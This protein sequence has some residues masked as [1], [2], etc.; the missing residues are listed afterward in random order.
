M[1]AVLVWRIAVVVLAFDAM[2][3][4]SGTTITFTKSPDTIQPSLTQQMTLRCSLSD[5]ASTHAPTTAAPSGG[6]LVGRRDAPGDDIKFVTSVV[7]ARDGLD[8]ASVSEHVAAR[9][10]ADAG[11][12]SVEGKITNTVGE[13][14]FLELTWEDP[15]MTQ[16]GNYTC[17]VAGVDDVGHNV[18]YTTYSFVAQA[19]LSIMDLIPYIHAQQVKARKQDTLNAELTKELNDLRTKD[20]ETI[21]QLND[22]QSKDAETTKQLNDLNSKVNAMSTTLSEARHIESGYVDCGN[23]GS[24]GTYWRDGTTSLRGNAARYKDITVRFRKSYTNTPGVQVGVKDA[25]LGA[26]SE[27]NFGVSV[28]RSD[29]HS[30]T[31]RCSLQSDDSSWMAGLRVSWISYAR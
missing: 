31:V 28:A 6:S 13:R 3:S 29:T 24:D 18:V 25:Y 9:G 19:D 12:L 1:A 17:V 22:L 10:L 14:G 20:A 2:Y 8:I 16:L 11:S 7:V 4:S 27:T 15:G 26:Q 30:F 5:G 21:K 23:A